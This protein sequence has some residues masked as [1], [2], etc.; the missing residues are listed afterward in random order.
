MKQF[1]LILV[2]SFISFSS[3]SQ[4][5]SIMND[6]NGQP[7][8]I[9]MRLP[10]TTYVH[11][12]KDGQIPEHLILGDKYMLSP[13][14]LFEHGDDGNHSNYIGNMDSIEPGVLP[15]ADL[16]YKVKYSPD[17]TK[18][19]AMYHHT[20]NLYVYDTETLE[21]LA[22]INVG[23]GPID[24]EVNEQHIYV[25][26]YYSDD[27]Y[28]IN[29]DDYSVENSFP[30]EHQPCVIEVNAD[31]SIIYVGFDNGEH[32]DAGG[33]LAAYG[34]SAFNQLFL[35]YWPYIGEMWSGGGGV[36][37][38]IYS[39][40]DFLLIGNDNY[41]ASLQTAGNQPIIL[42]AITGE[43]EKSFDIYYTSSL[44][45]TASKDSLY[46][47]AHRNDSL[48]FYCVDSYTHNVVDSMFIPQIVSMVFWTW[49]D[50]M[51]VNNDG[52]KLFIE[53]H[54]LGWDDYA[55]LVDFGSHD[56]IVF[57]L[58]EDAEFFKLISHDGRY[59]ILTGEYIRVFDFETEDY[60]FGQ[61]QSPHALNKVIAISP[62]SYEFV[63]SDNPGNYYCTRWKRD[64][65]IDV[66]NFSDPANVVKT[67]SIFCGQEPEADL[68]H[69]AVLNNHH[70]KIITGNP[71][72][73]NISIIDAITYE[74]DAI[75]DIEHISSVV[76]VGDDLIALSGW[77]S[78]Y[79]LLF[80]LSTLSIVKEFHHER[81]FILIP[82]PDKQYLY[83]YCRWEGNLIKISIDGSNSFIV[84]S[85][86]IVDYV[87]IFTN[88]DY[89]YSPEISPDG[90]YI[91]FHG[92]GT[93]KIV[94]TETMSLVSEVS[95]SGSGIHD[96][97][98]TDDSKRVCIAYWWLCTNYFDIIYL[99]GENS[100][101]ENTVFSP[102]GE[103]GMS[104]A[105][106]SIDKKFYIAK[107]FDIWVVDPETAIVEDTINLNVKDSQIQIGIS[108]QG[109]PFV[110]T[111]KYFYFDDQEIYL[112]EPT[113]K[114]YVDYASQKC[115]IPSPGPDRVYILDFLTTEI[116][117]IPVSKV[118]P[119]VHIY[120]NP[121]HD[122]LTIKSGK[123]I[124][125][126][127]IF[128]SSGEKLFD[129]K[130][131]NAITTLNMAAYPEGIYIVKIHREEDISVQKVLVVH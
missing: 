35:T 23:D 32:L 106:N 125:R 3:N 75:L 113:R 95:V 30:V 33:F 18:L 104:V 59:V 93:M 97:A 71:L 56:Y 128:N 111:M 105:F 88:V 79:L 9:L 47:F 91:L 120:P 96:M 16:P 39:Y 131:R 87:A 78:P 130:F 60:T 24:M 41:I 66:Y 116:H 50:N 46:I 117:E 54:G 123:L 102:V 118:D 84:S 70:S 42:N 90:K 14:E 15:E 68:I 81:Y 98:F 94:D 5:I 61:F 127:E 69:S 57:D 48:Y 21:P 55:Y 110:N 17:G 73:G 53:V 99:D 1:L 107:E 126:I 43:I 67:D 36:G 12:I 100:Y 22:I 27:I 103:G 129:K 13:K 62:D 89:R 63:I 19:I 86:D 38:Q 114:F 101:L 10:D 45:A 74:V 76:N 28:I 112:K 44:A 121:T 37:R 82:S 4:E 6:D 77:D 92:N 2:F 80:D 72:S 109:E 115:I 85:L 119:D 124:R 34:L 25:C 51:A 52:S 108:P 83:A 64:E 122:K 26:C 7:A 29:L 11:H 65:Y 49:Q 8:A 58:D 31:E 20:N 40:S